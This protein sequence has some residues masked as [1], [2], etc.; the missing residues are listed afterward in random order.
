MP[1]TQWDSN[2]KMG[3]RKCEQTEIK[4]YDLKNVKDKYKIH[5]I[6]KSFKKIQKYEKLYYL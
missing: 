4:Y 5:N 3:T 6:D 2:R 1:R